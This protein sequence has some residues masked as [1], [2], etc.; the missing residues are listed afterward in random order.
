MKNKHLLLILLGFGLIGCD[1][2]EETLQRKSLDG[3]LKCLEN[4]EE[5]INAVSESYVQSA[6][7][8]KHSKLKKGSS[9]FPSP[10][11]AS[12]SF[13]PANITFTRCK[14]NT[15]KIITSIVARA[16]IKNIENQDDIEINT[17]RGE[18]F[19]EPNGLMKKYLSLDDSSE[20]KDRFNDFSE[21]PYCKDDHIDD[22]IETCKGWSIFEYSYIDV[23]I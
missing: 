6:C 14:N 19:V 12:V 2:A 21:V 20:F 7:A 9:G 1:V 15:S 8:K 16:Y 23:D 11:R 5:K 18:I 17:V 3:Y 4:N 10:C 13:N 22:S